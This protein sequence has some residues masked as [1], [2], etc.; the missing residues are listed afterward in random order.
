MS[1]PVFAAAAMLLLDEGKF[2]LDDPVTKWAP[3]LADRRVMRTPGSEIDDTI[4]ARRAITMFDVLSY[5]L[6]I[7]VHLG[8][9]RRETNH[10]WDAMR[11][12]GVAPA[13][14][15][16]AFGADE[17]MS[18]LGSLPLAHHPG[19]TFMY[20]TA[21]DVLRVLISRISG[22]PL[23]AFLQERVFEP[24]RMVDSGLSVPEAK[25]HRFATAYMPQTNPGDD[26]VVWDEPDGR[27]AADPA[28]PSS[29]VSTAGD[30]LNF[31]RMLLGEGVFQGRRLLSAESVA[32]MMTD[33][34]TDQQKQRSPAPQGLWENRG[35]G[36]GG[37]VY[38]RS[39][40][41]GPSA[42]SY[43][44]FGGFG[45]YFVVDPKRGSASIIMV[46]RFVT[47]LSGELQFELDTFGDL[48]PCMPA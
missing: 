30:Y 33:H 23:D 6:G 41:H 22:R 11:G 35:W 48:L 17:F 46:Q 44:W 14:E 26:L 25:R 3:E 12:A 9:D 15:L 4:P 37:T 31:T 13:A 24:L 8:A 45:G 29:I 7:G 19:E 28:F 10:L 1:K 36:M 39:V 43:G 21:D 34:L 16:C 40:P 32:L 38:T 20:H 27:F 42:G 5:Q 18:R 47:S 2:R